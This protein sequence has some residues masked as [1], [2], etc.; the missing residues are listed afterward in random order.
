MQG[1]TLVGFV[2]SAYTRTFIE[3]PWEWMAIGGDKALLAH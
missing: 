1:E 3:Q 2:F